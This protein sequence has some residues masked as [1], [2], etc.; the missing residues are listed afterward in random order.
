MLATVVPFAVSSQSTSSASP[1]AGLSTKAIVASKLSSPGI[2]V[3]SSSLVNQPSSVLGVYA[4]AGNPG[5][6]ASFGEWLGHPVKYAMDFFD[7]SSWSTISKPSWIVNRWA[8]T[9]YQMI[10]G[11]PILPNSGASLS[12]GATGAYN[13]YFAELSTFLVAHGQG[14]SILRLGWEFNGSWFPWAASS[15]PQ[16]FIQYWR[17]IVTTMR[18]IPGAHFSFE[19]NPTRGQMS[20]APPDAWPG[21]AYVN[22]IGMDVYDL[23][24]PAMPNAQQRW[25]YF[26]SEPYGLNWLASFAAAH[27]KPISFP[28]WGLV[29]TGPHGHGGGDNP[30]F[31]AGMANFIASHN[32]VNAVFWNYGSSAIT[33]SAYPAAAATLRKDFVSGSYVPPSAN[34]LASPSGSGSARGSEVANGRS[35]AAKVAPKPAAAV[36]QGY[37]G[38]VPPVSSGQWHLNGSARLSE[39]WLVLTPVTAWKRGSAIWPRPV[40]TSKLSV[41]F[42]AT[43]GGGTGGNGLTL[44][45]LSPSATPSALGENGGGEGFAGLPGEAV[46]LQTYTNRKVNEVSIVDRQG[47]RWS[48]LHDVAV[49]RSVPQLR[50]RTVSVSVTVS[51]GTISVGIDGRPV[52]QSP[53]DLPPAAL[54][55]F[56]AANGYFTDAHVVTGVSIRSC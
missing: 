41:T 29:R 15:N 36:S 32:V 33:T 16:A 50:T 7:G 52:L 39:G 30:V 38:S 8:G 55:G 14:S 44:M 37:C 43:I 31:I 23:Q 17:Q 20:L 4:G 51:N 42:T 21:S 12:E 35:S 34:A 49:S 25:Q 26:L 5:A 2:A 27:N 48:T 22:I 40:S 19:W 28:E 6:V 9:P 45:F 56:S 10:W 46:S 1:T 54:V 24:W 3:S 11:V 13:H 53:A 18:A 47:S